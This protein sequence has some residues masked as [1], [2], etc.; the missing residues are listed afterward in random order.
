MESP[1]GTGPKIGHLLG[2]RMWQYI[3]ECGFEL[4]KPKFQT[5]QFGVRNISLKPLDFT[6]LDLF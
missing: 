2:V 1:R 4:W 6:F 3:L 5:F